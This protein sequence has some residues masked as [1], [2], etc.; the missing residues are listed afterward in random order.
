M[1]RSRF[2]AGLSLAFLLA[3]AALVTWPAGAAAHDLHSLRS[4]GYAK[5]LQA[6]QDRQAAEIEAILA[7]QAAEITAILDNYA[8]ERRAILD[9][10]ELDHFTEP[11]RP[12]VANAGVDQTAVVGDTITLDGSKSSDPDGDPLSYTWS[13]VSKPAESRAVLSAPDK[14]VTTFI[15]DAAGQFVVRLVV[16]DGVENATAT[17]K[18]DQ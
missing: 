2:P 18:T 14:V 3:A 4:L 17:V 15:V 12:P 10:L 11:N 16:N 13:F 7:K 8:A 1:Q 9:K 6:I 5:E